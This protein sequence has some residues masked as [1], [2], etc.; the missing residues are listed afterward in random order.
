MAASA[1]AMSSIGYGPARFL[2]PD[3]G[4]DRPTVLNRCSSRRGCLGQPANDA[5][6][7][8]AAVLYVSR[9]A[10][11]LTSAYSVFGH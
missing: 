1:I 9:T 2:L 3:E 11:A 4:S 7:K 8:G 5:T 6:A 10:V